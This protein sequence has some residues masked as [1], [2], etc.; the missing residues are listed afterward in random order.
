MGVALLG[1]QAGHLSERALR[2]ASLIASAVLAAQVTG[3]RLY[4]RLSKP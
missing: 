2:T 3:F 1:A 4:L